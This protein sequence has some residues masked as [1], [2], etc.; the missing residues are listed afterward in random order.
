MVDLTQLANEEI[1]L[2]V[3]CQRAKRDDIIGSSLQALILESIVVVGSKYD[4]YALALR[5]VLPDHLEG[6]DLAS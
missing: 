6:V 5:L 1:F 3:R 2:V 4:E